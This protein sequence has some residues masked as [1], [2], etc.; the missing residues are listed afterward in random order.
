VFCKI[1]K[2]YYGLSGRK[3]FDGNGKIGR[4]EWREWSK[5]RIIIYYSD[6]VCFS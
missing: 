5:C 2:Y 4:M 6:S 1:N 3:Y